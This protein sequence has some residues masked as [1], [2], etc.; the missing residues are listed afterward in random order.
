VGRRYKGRYYSP[1]RRAVYAQGDLIEP[2]VLFEKYNWICN[3]CEA[4]INK[5][6][7]FPHYWAATIEHVIPICKGGTHTWENCRPAHAICNWQKGDSLPVDYNDAK[8]IV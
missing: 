8:L 7:R 6:L 2:L 4:E 1:K 3:I 5:R